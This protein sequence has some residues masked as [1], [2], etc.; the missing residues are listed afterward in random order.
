MESMPSGDLLHRAS[1]RAYQLAYLIL[2]AVEDHRDPSFA[3]S[4]RSLGYDILFL[5]SCAKTYEASRSIGALQYFAR[6]GSDAGLLSTHDATLLMNESNEVYHL[7]ASYVEHSASPA[8]RLPNE[9]P[10]EDAFQSFLSVYGLR[11]D[12]ERHKE[13]SRE[14]KIKR[15]SES[16]GASVPANPIEARKNRICEHIA[17]LGECRLRDIADALPDISERTLRYDLQDLSERGIVE[18]VGYSGTK[19][20]YRIK[21]GVSSASSAYS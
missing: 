3:S 12:D 5:T 14:E 1:M 7:I 15:E 20:R 18:K 6:F 21:N 2:R 13:E 11:S 9:L 8:S 16:R 17:A 4:L 19:T 10:N